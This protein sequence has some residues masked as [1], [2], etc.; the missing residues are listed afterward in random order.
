MYSMVEGWGK[1]S[2]DEIR[3]WPFGPAKPQAAEY[4]RPTDLPDIGDRL[5]SAPQ[6]LDGRR[7]QLDLRW[8]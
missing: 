1:N 6:W 7:W 4:L 3:I 8:V 2:N 5:H